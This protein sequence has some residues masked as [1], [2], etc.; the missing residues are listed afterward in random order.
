MTEDVGSAAEAKGQGGE[1]EPGG[2]GTGKGCLFGCLGVIA[3][4]LLVAFVPVLLAMSGVWDDD[5]D[6]E[7]TSSQAAEICEEWVSE[8]LKSPSTADFS[9]ERE[10][11]TGTDSWT[12]TGLVD[13]Q[14]SFGAMIRAEWR[15]DVRWDVAG[16]RWRGSATLIE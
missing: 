9:E 1:S 4:L 3:V 11:S 16:E 10:S 2:V 12:I 14:N 5:G 6:W 7:P 15:C 13:A 8:K